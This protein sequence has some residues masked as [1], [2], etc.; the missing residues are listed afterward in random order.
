MMTPI[1]FSNDK[2]WAEFEETGA[3][4]IG[5]DSKALASPTVSYSFRWMAL[6]LLVGLALG[7]ALAGCL[8]ASLYAT[9]DYLS[10]NATD[11]RFIL[12]LYG[13]ALSKG[14]CVR[15]DVLDKV[16]PTTGRQWLW[17]HSC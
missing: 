11:A 14:E 10:I 3:L 7:G 15:V 17:L 16:D 1:T 9:P 12:D 6:A 8:V 5:A 2:D 13:E 4:P